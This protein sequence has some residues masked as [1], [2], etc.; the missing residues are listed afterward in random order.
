VVVVEWDG[1]W[2]RRQGGREGKNV[3]GCVRVWCLMYQYFEREGERE[4]GREARKRKGL[5]CNVYI[6]M[7]VCVFV[8]K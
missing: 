5:L 2:K 4:R 7:C 1:F 6:Y 3:T 8:C